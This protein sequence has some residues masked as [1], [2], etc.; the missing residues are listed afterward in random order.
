MKRSYRI[1]LGTIFT[2][3]NHLVG[4]L[5]DVACFERAELSRGEEILTA[6]KDVVGGMLDELRNGGATVQPL[7]VA[8][9][10][11][12]GILSQEC[13]AELKNELMERLQDSLPVDGVLLPFHG[14]AAVEGIGDLEGDLLEQIRKLVGPRLPIVAT[15]DMHAHVTEKMIHNADALLAWETYPHRDT[16]Q[17]GVRGARILLDVLEGKIRPAMAMAKVP[18]IVSGFN[19][20]TEGTGPFADTMRMAKSFEGRP[21]VASTNVFLVQPHLDVP[22]MGGGGLVITHDEMETAVELA[23]QIAETY[24]Q[25]RFDLE[26]KVWDLREAIAQGLRQEGAPLLLLEISDCVGGGAAGDSVAALRVL[27]EAGVNEPSLALVVDPAAAAAC[28]QSAVGSQVTLTLGHRVDPQWGKPVTLTARIEKLT[29]GKFLYSGGIWGGLEGDMGPAV[30]LR[31]GSLELLVASH[32][33]YEWA[34][35]QYR[36]MEMDTHAAKFIVVKNPMNYR[37]GYGGK[38][39]KAFVLDTPGPTTPVVERV[40]F[41]NVARPYFPVDRDISGLRPVVFRH[42]CAV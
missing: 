21:G 19:G 8:T 30:K 23:T 4:T 38:F 13:Y 28:H 32:P 12:G 33:T 35:E 39:A 16:Y 5:T 6:R 37:V 7:L 40:P 1:G 41:Q 29:D 15:L 25:R 2:E 24:W 34:D 17:T 3:S 27:L 20:S 31:I 36:S 9:A 11:P 42:R 18:V 22:G 10:A 14:A 26:P